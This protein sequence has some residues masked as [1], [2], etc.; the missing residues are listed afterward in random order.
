MHGNLIFSYRDLA[1]N[2]G[3]TNKTANNLILVPHRATT[4]F[5]VR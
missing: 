4:G 3:K 2:Q 5:I 1:V